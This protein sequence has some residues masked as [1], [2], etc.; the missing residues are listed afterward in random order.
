V[1]GCANFALRGNRAG[2]NSSRKDG[3]GLMMPFGEIVKR[4]QSLAGSFGSPVAL[5]AFQLAPEQTG[6]IFTAMD[7]DYHISRY[8]NFSAEGGE[9]YV[10]SGSA[11]T[12]VRI[13]EGILSVL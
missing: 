4:Y 12:H 5:S 2:L 11:V 13:D 9:E 10:I 8:L 1:L 6:A 3:A 7:E